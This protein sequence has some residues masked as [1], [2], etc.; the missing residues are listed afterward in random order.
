MGK[1]IGLQ[2]PF[3]SSWVCFANYQLREG[4]TASPGLGKYQVR[5]VLSL[6]ALELLS[7]F[8]VRSHNTRILAPVIPALHDNTL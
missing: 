8:K 3:T 5:E 1:H 6:L 2:A 7:P 4:V